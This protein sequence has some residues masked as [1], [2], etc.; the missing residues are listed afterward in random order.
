[1]HRVRLRLPAAARRRLAGAAA[2]ARRPHVEQQHSQSNGNAG[3]FCLVGFD[4]TF[5][6]VR[7]DSLRTG[8]WE[9]SVSAPHRSMERSIWANSAQVDGADCLGSLRTCH[10]AD[11]ALVD[12]VGS[13]HA[14]PRRFCWPINRLCLLTFYTLHIMTGC[15]PQILIRGSDAAVVCITVHIVVAAIDISQLGSKPK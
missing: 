5:E 2:P 4:T 7:L 11:S 6:H 13:H 1:M 8:R 9:G 15:T 14:G 12:G 10:Y 3:G